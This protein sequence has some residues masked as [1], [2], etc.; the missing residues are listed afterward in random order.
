MASGGGGGEQLTAPSRLD[1]LATR[2]VL[3]GIAVL[4]LVLQTVSAR[5]LVTSVETPNAGREIAEGLAAGGRYEAAYGARLW[6]PIAAMRERPR[7][8]LLPAEPLY[9][10]AVFR[11]LP[12]SLHRYAHVPITTLLVVAVAAFAASFGGARLGAAAG[13]LGAVQPFVVLHGPVWDDTFL[14]AAMVWL[15]LAILSREWGRG[16]V[17]RRSVWQRSFP[18]LGVAIASATAGLARLEA[19]LILLGIAIATMAS[20][21]LRELR[22]EGMAIAA[23]IVLALG[24]WGARNYSAV[25]TFFVGS[26]HDGIALWESNGPVARA[27]LR[28]GQVMT[29]SLD[30]AI[31]RAHWDSTAGMSEVEANAYFRRAGTRYML[32]HPLDVG[33]TALLKLTLSITGMRPELPIGSARNIVALATNALLIALAVWGA[34]AL[35]TTLPSEARRAM[36]TMLGIV[37]AVGLAMLVV[38]PIGLRYRMTLDGVLWICG[39]ATLA[40]LTQ[41][42]AT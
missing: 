20:S 26:T 33:R 22:R 32:E 7:A 27:A 13:V 31:M 25:G 36:L 16:V 10:A 12:P 41:R 6:G 23:G 11:V 37:V 19:Q 9:L 38:G 34:R 14:A 17:Q 18:L 35:A 4:T 1:R 21:S 30:T 24:A 5:W 15:V 40:R 39:G 8:Y 2:R 3:A 28:R 42:Y 29:L